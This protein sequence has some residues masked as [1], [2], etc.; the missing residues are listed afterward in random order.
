MKVKLF[1]LGPDFMVRLDKEWISTIKEFK[2]ILQR[3][4]GSKG[5]T[6]GKKKIQAQKEFTFIY[7]LCDYESK[8]W[9][10]SEQDWLTE[11]GRNAELGENFD[12]RK[13]EDI[14][15]AIKKYRE[16]Q[17]SPALKLLTEAKEGLHTAHKVIRKIRVSL[18][19]KLEAVDFDELEVEEIGK[20]DNKKQRV[21]DPVTKLT[22]N[23]KAL[24]E[25]TNQVSPALKT[26]K[27]LEEEVR[28]ELGE[29]QNLR[30]GKVKGIREDGAGKQ[31]PRINEALPEEESTGR[32]GIFA[33]I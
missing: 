21:N 25:L 9:N 32:P 30:G 31:L 33:D 12:Y 15:V 4:R 22:N 28:K 17:E 20:G 18:E 24:M 27:E 5:D 14:V 2:K 10:F 23:L 7:H 13:D 19:T 8:F 11:A 16:L 26:I 6:E 1:E 29:K 3:D